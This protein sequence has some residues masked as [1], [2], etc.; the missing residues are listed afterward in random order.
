MEQIRWQ[1]ALWSSA[2]GSWRRQRADKRVD[3]PRHGGD[4]LFLDPSDPPADLGRYPPWRRRST[5]KRQIGSTIAEIRR[6]GW[7]IFDIIGTL[8]QS[9]SASK[10]SN[11]HQV[12]CTFGSQKV[13]HNPIDPTMNSPLLVADS[14][15]SSLTTFCK[16]FWKCRKESFHHG[17]NGKMPTTFTAS[18]FL[19]HPIEFQDYKHTNFISCFVCFNMPWTATFKT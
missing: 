14:V 5:D 9:Y 15:F 8:V 4:P 16:M 18:N 17:V 12:F 3:P 11:H 19:L 13:P 1:R 7:R 10:A 6:H 2:G